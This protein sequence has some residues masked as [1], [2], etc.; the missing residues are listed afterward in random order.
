MPLLVVGGETPARA[1]NRQPETHPNHFP[2]F[3]A[4]SSIIHPHRNP[5]PSRRHAPSLPIQPP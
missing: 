2:R 5:C 4:A 3:Q 1:N